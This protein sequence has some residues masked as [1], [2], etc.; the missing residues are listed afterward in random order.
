MKGRAPSPLRTGRQPAS[1][2][3]L[4]RR[5]DAAQHRLTQLRAQNRDLTRRLETAHGEIR[6]LRIAS[7]GIDGTEVVSGSTP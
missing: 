7:P 3:S 5:L 6:R 2:D 4:Q 1:G